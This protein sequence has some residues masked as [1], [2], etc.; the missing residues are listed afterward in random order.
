MNLSIKIKDNDLLLDANVEMVDGVMIV[1]PVVNIEEPKFKDGDI[2]VV[3]GNSFK[4]IFLVGEMA[5]IYFN[6]N[7]ECFCY[8]G[9]DSEDDSMFTEGKYTVE[10]HATQIEKEILFEVLKN[11]GYRW[12]AEKRELEEIKWEPNKDEVYFSFFYNF[13]DNMF[14]CESRYWVG[15]DIELAKLD[16]GQIFQLRE[17]CQQLC[18]K[19]NQAIE[20]INQ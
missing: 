9:I 8:F 1:S 5:G 18:D 16:N 2:A 3:N 10:R 19:L 15:N 6:G 12:N 7:C 4:Q 14:K 11:K 17:E 20:S 13:R